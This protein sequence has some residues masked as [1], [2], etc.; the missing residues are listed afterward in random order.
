MVGCAPSSLNVDVQR[1]ILHASPE[2][3]WEIQKPRNRTRNPKPEPFGTEPA[4][5]AI[6]SEPNEPE[7]GF[8]YMTPAK[9]PKQA[10][11]AAAAAAA[12]A[13]DACLGSFAGVM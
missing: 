8:G 6:H 4:E 7:P 2:V 9:D 11:K 13:F 5:P 1:W 10:S 12:A 3:N